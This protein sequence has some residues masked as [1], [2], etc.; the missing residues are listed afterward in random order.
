MTWLY[1][2]LQVQPGHSHLASS[3]SCSPILGPNT[4]SN[5]PI[6]KK[7]GL[8]EIMLQ[9]SLLSSL[10]LKRAAAAIHAQRLYMP[11]HLCLDQGYAPLVG[12]PTR[13]QSGI[14]L[15]SISYHSV[16]SLGPKTKRIRFKDRVE[17]C[18]ASSRSG[19]AGCTSHSSCTIVMLPPTTLKRA[20]RLQRPVK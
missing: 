5:K 3:I 16:P 15:S 12:F 20:Q 18:I 19:P 13:L 6:L 9:R 10:F 4:L 14:L 17:Q 1:G 2:P 11:Q 7:K 8:S